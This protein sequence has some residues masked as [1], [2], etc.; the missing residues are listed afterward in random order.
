MLSNRKMDKQTLGYPYNG[1]LL[2]S[3]KKEIINIH[4][5]MDES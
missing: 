1:I 2:L 3:N 4:Y 5:N